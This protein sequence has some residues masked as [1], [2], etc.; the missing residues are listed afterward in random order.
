MRCI[1]NPL[2]GERERYF[3]F[4]PKIAICVDKVDVKCLLV[5]RLLVNVRIEFWML[6]DMKTTEERYAG[7]M[8]VDFKN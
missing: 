2:K 3:S 4:A 8:F 5:K 7:Y 1:G 6:K